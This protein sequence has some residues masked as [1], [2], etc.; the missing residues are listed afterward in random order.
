MKQFR[1]LFLLGLF[2]TLAFA[3]CQKENDPPTGP[4]TGGGTGYPMPGD[5]GGADPDNVI[6]IIRVTTTQMGISFSS[7]LGFADFNSQDVGTVKATVGTT[8]YEFTKETENNET[9]YMLINSASNPQGI[10]LGTG[11]ANVRIDAQNY[12]IQNN[13]ISVPGQI[14]LTAPA[15]NAN[16]PRNQD[17]NVTWNAA[18]GG[19]YNMLFVTDAQGNSR[20]KT[21]SAGAASGSFTASELSGLQAGTGIIYAISY[22]YVL[23]NNNQTVLIGQSLASTTINLQ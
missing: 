6:A 15:A 3:G 8:E 22:N 11:N 17:L 2:L 23:S 14:A 10:D 18:T 4:G 12:Q 9:S 19:Q 21:I 13:T 7:G 16:V 1:L 20:N 5:F